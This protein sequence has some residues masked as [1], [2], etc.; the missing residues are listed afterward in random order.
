[1]DN[2]FEERVEVLEKK[3]TCLEGITKV[4]SQMIDTLERLISNL[5]KQI[6]IQDEKTDLVKKLEDTN[7]SAIKAMMASFD[8]L[9]E[10]VKDSFVEEETE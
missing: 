4:Q 10:L 8:S 2:N 6:K 1:M 9:C 7:T 5:Q 3:V